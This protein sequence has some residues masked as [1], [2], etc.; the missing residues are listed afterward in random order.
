[1]SQQFQAD[2]QLLAAPATITTT[3]ETQGPK[4]NFLTP[5]YGS[6]KAKV[7]AV[8]QVVVGTATTS[9]T[10]QIRRN[11]NGENVAI[12]GFASIPVTVGQQPVITVAGTDQ[13]N[14]G[15]SV[16]YVA[17]VTQIAATGNGTIN[18]GS[19]IEATILSG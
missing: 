7:V 3:T 1:M 6:F 19:Y 2:A 5:P 11:P 18:A 12:N 10:V 4:T 13:V 16:Q 15:R 14:D 17:T 9:L 8:V